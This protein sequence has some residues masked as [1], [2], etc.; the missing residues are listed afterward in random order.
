MN[1][2]RTSLKGV[3]AA[4]LT[5]MKD[6]LTIDH[7][8]LIAHCRW[9]LD[10]GCNAIAFMGTTGEANS[11]SVAERMIALDAVLEAGIAPELLMVGTGCCALPDTLALTRHAIA[12]GVGGMLMLPPFYYKG[13]SEEGVF[14]AFDAAIQRVGH[15][16]LRIYLY[17]FPQMSGVP[18]SHALIER[19]LKKYPDVIAG[20]KDSSGDFENMRSMAA[21]F[22][23]FDVFAGTERYLLDIM[24][25]GGVGCISAS[26]NVTCP[27]R[28]AGL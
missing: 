16:G 18:F 6:D 14:A 2:A 28:S 26:A 8:R 19:L 9:L 10:N 3:M 25:A 15:D 7:E 11:L 4:S 22:P 20:I 17:H 23:G 13:V 27:L 12:Q 24:R 21:H 5:P 1:S